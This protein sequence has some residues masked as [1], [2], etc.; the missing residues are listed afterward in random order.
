M[1]RQVK[2]RNILDKFCIDFCRVVE[3]HC[4]Y[5]IVSGFVAI[6][7][8][9]SRGTEDID[10]IIEKI[11]AKKFGILHRDLE[12]KGFECVQSEDAAEIFDY[13]LGG[14]SIRYIKRKILVP[15]MEVKFAKD[16]IDAYQISTR[17][18]IKFTGL[19]VW[20]S[21]V[22][23]NIAF[24]EEYLKSDKDMSDAK[25]L[26]IV[27]SDDIDEDEIGKIKSMIRRYRL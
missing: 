8:G 7:S 6:A 15:E 25:H 13:L 18:K 12:R 2:K 22:N 3:R 9:R 26:R 4:K 24:K 10:M 27:Y 23:A 11:T 1:D 14:N 17:Q 21:S 19:P 16:I 20:F 5:I